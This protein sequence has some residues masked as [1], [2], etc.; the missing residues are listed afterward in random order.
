MDG[1][2]WSGKGYDKNGIKA[3]EIRD[4]R[5][6]VKEYNKM[7]RLIYKGEYLNG[8]R[9]GK[10][11]EYLND[12]RTLFEGEYLNGERWIWKRIFSK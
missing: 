5:G 4:G 7:G 3:F 9:N 10:G 1:K 8:E 11:K 6:Q 12:G 2:R